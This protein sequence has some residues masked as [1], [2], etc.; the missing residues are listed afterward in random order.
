[1]HEAATAS[2]EP[3][4]V[5]VVIDGWIPGT[6]VSPSEAEA[7]GPVVLLLHGFASTRDEVGSMFRF[8]ANAMAADG[9]SS[10]RIDFVSPTSVDPQS[11]PPFSEQIAMAATALRWLI[12]HPCA[13]ASR[14][15]VVG[16][17]LGGAVAISL[18][19]RVPQ[20]VAAVV[21]WSS[22]GDVRHD[23]GASLGPIARETA[24]REG[25]VIVDLG[26]RVV[27][28]SAAFFAGLDVEASVE[29]V[30]RITC[31]LGIVYGA[32]DPL[33]RYRDAIVR[34]HGTY[35]TEDRILTATGHLLGALDADAEVSQEVIGQTVRWMAS[36]LGYGTPP[37]C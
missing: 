3:S 6:M 35:A 16:F 24:L 20:D 30:G 12:S 11:I 34:N 1:M 32:D 37:G 7:A 15:G 14:V 31:P 27:S 23:L 22:S 19:A 2:P 25:H 9:I 5:E 4:S 33:I 8:L 21:L 36:W 26:F 17:S 29:R 10:L 18:A 13:D 28:L